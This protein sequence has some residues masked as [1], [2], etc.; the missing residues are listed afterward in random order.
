MRAHNARTRR[1]LRR[2]RRTKPAR[3]ARACEPQAAVEDG[4]LVL[5]QLLLDLEQ[6]F[7]LVAL[8]VRLLAIMPVVPNNV[9]NDRG[10][11]ASW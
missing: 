2:E 11:G 10:P 6:Q 7:L 4:G 1:L 3:G 8:A 5:V 9:E